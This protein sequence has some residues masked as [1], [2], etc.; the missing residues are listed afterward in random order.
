MEKIR[1]LLIGNSPDDATATAILG[2]FNPSIVRVATEQELTEQLG[3]AQWDL[4]L[5]GVWNQHLDGFA[6]LAIVRSQFPNLPFI[7]ITSVSYTENAV[8]AF[9]AGATDYI[10]QE[11]MGTD[12]LPAVTRAL[13]TV[14]VPQSHDLLPICCMCKKIRDKGNLWHQLE[15]F[16]TDHFK[17]IFTHTFCPECFAMKMGEI[18][19]LTKG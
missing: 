16:L 10:L 8:Q 14:K 6:A 11:G 12:L 4:V 19:K 17:I 1:I 2:D 5:S 18:E 7:F 9:R 13:E 3:R 15:N